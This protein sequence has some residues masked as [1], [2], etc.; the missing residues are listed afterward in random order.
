MPDLRIQSILKNSPE[1][2]DNL[3][4]REK[5]QCSLMYVEDKTIHFTSIETFLLKIAVDKSSK[6]TIKTTQDSIE[7]QEGYPHR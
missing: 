5:N 6:D 3:R 1:V 7:T 2:I 4:I